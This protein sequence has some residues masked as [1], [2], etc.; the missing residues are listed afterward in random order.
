M[1]IICSSTGSPHSGILLHPFTDHVFVLFSWIADSNSLI[2]SRLR[3]YAIKIA[4]PADGIRQAQS[5]EKHVSTVAIQVP[6]S[7]C[8]S[9]AKCGVISS[10][11][12]SVLLR[13]TT[14][15]TICHAVPVKLVL[16]R[17]SGT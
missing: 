8:K 2:M 3:I 5:A 13:T 16:L 10:L 11:S 6:T 4:F 15:L 7:V 12:Y 9:G 1:L 14:Q 17:S